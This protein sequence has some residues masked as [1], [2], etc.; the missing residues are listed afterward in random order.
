MNLGFGGQKLI[1]ETID[2]IKVLK[3]YITKNDL[4][5]DIEVDGGVTLEN[6][7]ELKNAG[8]NILVAGTTI[9]KADNKK[10]VI[11]NLKC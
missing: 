11:K 4:D 8:S 3:D 1:P 5:V 7:A 6:S 9:F 2:K 10:E